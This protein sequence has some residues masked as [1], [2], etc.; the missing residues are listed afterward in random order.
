MIRK[1]KNG[2]MPQDR[3]LTDE[4]KNELLGWLQRLQAEGNSP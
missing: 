2:A 4:Q 1:I 3:Q